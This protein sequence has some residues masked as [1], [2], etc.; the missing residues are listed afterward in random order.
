MKYSLTGTP[1]SW[2]PWPPLTG[3]LDLG[4]ITAGSNVTVFIQGTLLQ[5]ANM[6]ITNTATV[7]S[8]SDPDEKNSTWITH[9]KTADIGI[10]KTTS[11]KTPN[12]LQ[13]VKFTIKAHNY[14]PDQATGVIVKDLLPTG[15]KLISY[16]VTQGSYGPNSGI[17]NVG[18]INN[19][20]SA[21][22][23]IIAQVIKTGNITNTANKTAENEYDPNTTNNQDSKTIKVPQAADLSITK[24]AK[25]TNPHLQQTVNFTLIVQNH[26]P[27]TALEVYVADKLPK[28]LKYI[29]SSANYGQYDPNNGKWIIGTLPKGSV[30]ILTIKVG[31]EITGT[32]KN[33]AKVYSITYD[34]TLNNTT[35]TASVVVKGSNNHHHG[36]CD[37]G[38]TI[39]MQ[40][41]G[42]PISSLIMG[43]L[44]IVAGL[45]VT[46][47]KI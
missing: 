3:Y 2:M 13:N 35:A 17:W 46:R 29:S 36:N 5:S 7:T 44:M 39:P 37:H 16:S 26:G 22:L 45:V 40:D 34:P 20:N 8:T 38:H 47:R 15:L 24:T 12:Y 28:G 19:G 11:N 10:T 1:G 25:P 27:D 18:T 23:T 30:A 43:M 31:V 33:H 32:I 6:D 41:T 14:G 42:I 4:T 9:L 21:Y